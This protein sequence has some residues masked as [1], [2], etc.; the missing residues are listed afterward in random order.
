[1]QLNLPIFEPLAACRN[2]LV[3]G[4]G[5][6]FDVFCGLPIFF[7]LQE[8]GQRAHLANL[9]FSPTDA[10]Q[11]ATR[12]TPALAGVTA[13]APSPLL[14]AVGSLLADPQLAAAAGGGLSAYFPERHLARW[15]REQR[16]QEV[17]VWCFDKTGARPLRDSYRRLVEHLEIDGLL[18]VDGGVDSLA[19]GDEAEA[20]TFVED[21]ISLAAVAALD[22]VPVRIMACLGLG[23]ERDIAYAHVLE[24]IAGLAASGGFLGACALTRQMP[25]YQDYEAALLYVQGAPFQEPSVINSS[26]VSAVRGH[27][28][29]Y[30]LTA[31]THGSALWISPLMALYW[32]FDLPAVARRN[33][34]IAQV[35]ATETFREA[36]RAL[37]VARRSI[38]PRPH[39]RIPLP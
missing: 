4:M 21:A 1:M 7:A 5:G 11:G 12:L 18:L 20:G 33:Q 16:G 38:A 23:A 15:F 10:I 28:G 35:G 30:H 37:M 27:Y 19:R 29:D 14:D 24:N 2:V 17:T 9:T 34:M 8:R 6:G 36:L 31:K 32:F 25:A 22:D 13:D 39:Q 26:V 3:A